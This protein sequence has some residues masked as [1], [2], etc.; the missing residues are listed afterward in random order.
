LALGR[1]RR[2]DRSLAL[3]PIEPFSF[4]SAAR[5]AL[6]EGSLNFIFCSWR[7]GALSGRKARL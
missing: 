1:H 3:Q 4:A 5:D 2:I 7:A 6:L